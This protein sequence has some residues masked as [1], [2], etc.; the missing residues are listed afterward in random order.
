MEALAARCAESIAYLHMLH[1]V[2]TQ[3][4]RNC[5]SDLSNYKEGYTLSFD[6]ERR[7]RS[8]LAFLSSIRNDPNYIP[9]ICIR[10]RRKPT[11]LDVLV[12]VNKG[13]ADDGNDMLRE[14]ENGF[15]KLFEVLSR[16]CDGK[17]PATLL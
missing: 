12:A 14:L 4:Q 6:E 17:I 3:P 15:N 2:P 8:V 11:S 13:H 5:T 16:A 10:E 7:L 1:A 9:A